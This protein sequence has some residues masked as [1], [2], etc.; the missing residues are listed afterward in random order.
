MSLLR[1]LSLHL[2]HLVALSLLEIVESI[3]SPQPFVPLEEIDEPI[4][5]PGFFINESQIPIQD[6]KF[7]KRIPNPH[8]RS[9]ILKIKSQSQIPDFQNES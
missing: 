6:P 7:S 5:N 1:N 9:Q 8:S 4:P 2:R 3:Y